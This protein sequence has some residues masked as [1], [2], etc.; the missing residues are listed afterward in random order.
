LSTDII[1]E[2]VT[3]SLVAKSKQSAVRVETCPVCDGTGSM[4]S[5]KCKECHGRG[6]V[7]RVGLEASIVA[8]VT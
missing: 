5:R 8:A 1:Y 7:Q 2:G 3:Y 6:L 4:Y